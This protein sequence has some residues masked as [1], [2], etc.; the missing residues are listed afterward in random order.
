MHDIPRLLAATLLIGSLAGCPSPTPS[1]GDELP[2]APTVV[3]F[4][5]RQVQMEDQVQL[6]LEWE[7]TGATEVTITDS[8]RGVVSG[9]DN[10]SSGAVE[11]AALE[12]DTLFVLVAK[13]SRGA[14]PRRWPPRAPSK[15][16]ESSSSWP[17]P[18]RSSR[19]SR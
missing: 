5:A 19:A 18:R 13:N 2:P 9:V 1:P 8:N 17:R 11:V 4:R 3:S 12:K 7:T 14:A 6:L 10:Q 15:A 16:R